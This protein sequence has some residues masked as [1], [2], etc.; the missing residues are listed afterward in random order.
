MMR[1]IRKH[2]HCVGEAIKD[3]MTAA[4]LCAAVHCGEKIGNPGEIMV[5][6]DDSIITD[7]QADKNMALAEIAA[8]GIPRLKVEYLVKYFG[9]SEEDAEKAV[10]AD[11]VIDA[12]F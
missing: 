3:V 12:G 8:L 10:P 2:E 4:M 1:N 5:N 9:M 11:L 6:W 7:T